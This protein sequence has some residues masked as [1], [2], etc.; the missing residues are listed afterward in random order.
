VPTERRRKREPRNPDR[1]YGDRRL[2]K[3]FR[4]LVDGLV[5]KGEIEVV[6]SP[7]G[8]EFKPARGPKAT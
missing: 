3:G 7:W 5:E 1:R 6:D 2:A 4:T 8:R